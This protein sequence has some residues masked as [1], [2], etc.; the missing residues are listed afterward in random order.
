MVFDCGLEVNHCGGR[1]REER[2]HYEYKNVDGKWSQ[3]P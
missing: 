1:T 3:R 2:K